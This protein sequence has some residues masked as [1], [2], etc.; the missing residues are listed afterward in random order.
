VRRKTACNRTKCQKGFPLTRLQV[1]L[2]IVSQMRTEVA[3]LARSGRKC[4]NPS[5]VEAMKERASGTEAEDRSQGKDMEDVRE[6]VVVE[7]RQARG[8][9][10][11]VVVPVHASCKI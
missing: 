8:G 6:R 1:V 9:V 2:A 5:L 4:L 7:T 3:K 11:V 10:A